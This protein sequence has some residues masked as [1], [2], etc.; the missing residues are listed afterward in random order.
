MSSWGSSYDPI[1]PRRKLGV[2][3]I[4]PAAPPQSIPR[5]RVKVLKPGGR[6]AFLLAAI[7]SWHLSFISHC[8]H[9]LRL[10]CNPSMRTPQSMERTLSHLSPCVPP[11]A[12]PW[13]PVAEVGTEHL[14]GS[15]LGQKLSKPPVKTVPSAPVLKR[16]PQARPG[17]PSPH[18]PAAHPHPKSSSA[19][20]EKTKAPRNISGCKELDAWGWWSLCSVS[21]S[22]MSY[23][24]IILIVIA[25]SCVLTRPGWGCCTRW[26][27]W[28]AEVQT[29]QRCGG[30]AALLLP[31]P[32]RELC[33][34]GIQATHVSTCYFGTVTATKSI[35]WTKSES[36]C[37]YK[38][39]EMFKHHNADV[40]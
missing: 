29:P 30:P 5:L 1:L 17:P 11:V 4:W 38:C 21:A 36:N 40:A 15:L 9:A 2:P 3:R 12:S 22:Q 25:Q 27:Y 24:I 6:W 34:A 37:K 32:F 7:A 23:D 14:D 31:E 19:L 26:G 20:T 39:L 35:N 10:H 16:H 8:G 18:S 28:K 33:P 13:A